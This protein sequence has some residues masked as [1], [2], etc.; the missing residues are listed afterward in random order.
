MDLTGAIPADAAS[1]VGWDGVRNASLQGDCAPEACRA[2]PE[3]GVEPLRILKPEVGGGI[4]E[5][6]VVTSD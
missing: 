5:R 3:Y 6:G 2:I 4:A 1:L